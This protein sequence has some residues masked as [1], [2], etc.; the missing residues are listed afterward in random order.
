MATSYIKVSISIKNEDK[1]SFDEFLDYVKED[2]AFK[3]KKKI[4]KENSLEND[5]GFKEEDVFIGVSQVFTKLWKSYL[6]KRKS[7]N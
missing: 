7:I 1:E 5:K 2:P 3:K 4:I 6:K